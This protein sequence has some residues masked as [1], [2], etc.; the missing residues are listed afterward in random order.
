[1][2]QSSRSIWRKHSTGRPPSTTTHPRKTNTGSHRKHF[3]FNCG[4][5]NVGQTTGAKAESH[6]RTDADDPT[7]VAH[8]VTTFHRSEADETS[9]SLRGSEGHASRARRG[10]PCRWHDSARSQFWSV[11]DRAPCLLERIKSAKTLAAKLKPRILLNSKL[12]IRWKEVELCLL[13][14]SSRRNWR[15]M[16]DPGR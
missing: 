5:C 6:G 7:S 11:F 3:Y 10:F 4:S 8:W 12:S 15:L 1:M 16:G 9:R 2:I 13:T 14:R